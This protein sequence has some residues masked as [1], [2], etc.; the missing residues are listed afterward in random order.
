MTFLTDV[1]AD[2]D[3]FLG[4]RATYAVHR[5]GVPTNDG[6]G[7]AIQGSLTVFSI[8]ASVQPASGRKVELLAEAA[9][10][11]EVRLVVTEAELDVAT[12]AHDADIVVIAG[13][14]WVVISAE[15]WGSHTRAYVARAEAP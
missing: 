14:E 11:S 1:I 10:V 6:S 15:R 8:D 3:G 13:E 4:T 2:A 7:R 9:K 12:P 5:R